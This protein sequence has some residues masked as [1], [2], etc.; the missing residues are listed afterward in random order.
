MHEALDACQVCS[1]T[2]ICVQKV[3]SNI[4]A[5][6]IQ[7]AHVGGSLEGIH[8]DGLTPKQAVDG[9]ALSAAGCADHQHGGIQH[10][11]VWVGF[12]LLARLLWGRVC[13]IVSAQPDAFGQSQPA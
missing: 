4:G 6:R 8:S 2:P 9:G 5:W 13:P 1:G 3:T 7:G 12:L 11:L 10:L